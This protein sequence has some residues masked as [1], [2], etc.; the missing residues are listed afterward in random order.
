MSE[1]F[2]VIVV[3]G[4]QSG[5]VAGYY[6][7]RAGIP[8]VIL[9]AKDEVGQSWR[10][11]WDS[12]ELFTIAAYCSLPGLRFPGN[13][14]RFPDKDEMAD[15]V[16]AY[17]RRFALPVRLGTTVTSL[18]RAARGYRLETNRG[19]YEADQVVVATG[20]YQ[21]QYV[22][23]IAAGLGPDVFQVHTGSYLNPGQIPGRRVVVV[24]A[25]NSGAQI[26]VDLAGSHQVLLSQGSPLPHGPRRF[27]GIGLHWW[28]DKLGIIAKPLIGERDRIHKKTILVGPSLKKLSKRHGFPLVGRTVAARG[29]TVT[30][31]DG[32]STEVDAVV[33]ATGFR[34]RFPWIDLPIFREDG[35]PEHFRGVVDQAPGLYFLGM[36]CQYSYGS[37]LIWW[38]KDDA[39]YLIDHV[40]SARQGTPVGAAASA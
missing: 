29:R 10:E 39:Q 34:P 20:A 38:V 15:Y 28:G 14:N 32:T 35:L 12:L 31:E 4:G 3:G 30:F 5:L 9:D 33:W 24:G 26:A 25:A 8:F 21:N 1:R 22:P 19:T 23:P 16:Q 17:Q 6:L 7:Q 2:E 40:A 11:R 27:L 36:Q 18:T 37:G 13:F